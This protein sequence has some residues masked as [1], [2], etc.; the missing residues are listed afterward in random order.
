MEC[1]EGNENWSGG[2]SVAQQWGSIAHGRL[3][4]NARFREERRNASAGRK[5][6]GQHGNATVMSSEQQDEQP[7]RIP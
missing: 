4:L 3:R 7:E 2:R 5:S 1:P 6:R